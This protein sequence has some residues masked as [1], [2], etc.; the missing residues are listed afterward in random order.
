MPE[1]LTSILTI[2][3]MH[4]RFNMIMR[5]ILPGRVNW[6]RQPALGIEADILFRLEKD[7]SGKPGLH[8]LME[9][10]PKPEI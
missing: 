6:F 8:A 10:C 3:G 2:I 7:M 5:G 9:E 4:P 1:L